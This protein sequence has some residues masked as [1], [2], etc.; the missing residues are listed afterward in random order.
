MWFTHCL[1]LIGWPADQETPAPA[2]PYLIEAPI[3]SSGACSLGFGVEPYLIGLL[4]L[5][6]GLG[7]VGIVTGHVFWSSYG[8]YQS[9]VVGA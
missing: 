7:G 8:P 4:V 5:S 2:Q 3:R 1:S 6:E 9:R